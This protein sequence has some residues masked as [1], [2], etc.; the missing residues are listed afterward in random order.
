MLDTINQSLLWQK[1][2]DIG[3][4]SKIVRIIQNLY[5]NASFQ[6]EINSEISDIIN[7]TEGVLHGEIISP[8]LFAILSMTLQNTYEMQNL[9][10]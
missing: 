8:L 6:I 3:K 5:K 1:L 9:K 7:I 4:S 10:V 2:F